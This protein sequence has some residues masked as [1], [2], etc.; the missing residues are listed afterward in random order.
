MIMKSLIQVD[1]VRLYKRIL[2][3]I[4]LAP[5]E[6]LQVPLLNGVIMLWIS[7]ADGQVLTV[8]VAWCLGYL[9]VPEAINDAA[10]V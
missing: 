3:L 5:C 4:F 7:K 1:L 8:L 6:D 9:L 2:Y 10:S